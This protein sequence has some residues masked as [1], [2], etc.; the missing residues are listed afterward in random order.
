[1]KD[2]KRG[3]MKK[4]LMFL[5]LCSVVSCSTMSPKTDSPASAP[6]A[7]QAETKKS[8]K[9]KGSI[10]LEEA[11]N[12]DLAGVQRALNISR[13][14]NDLG[15]IEKTF[16]TCEVGSG[17]SKVKNCRTKTFGLIHFRIQCRD[18]DG[19]T[20]EVVTAANL[21]AMSNQDLTWSMK[22]AKGDATTDAQ[23]YAQ[24]RYA[25]DGSQ[26]SQRLRVGT[27]TDFLYLKANEIKQVIVPNYWCR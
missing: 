23:G 13:D 21:A 11:E 3:F 15:V 10:V 20:S 8:S 27:K 14:R 9:E 26:K 18:T 25:A 2:H 22:N 16:N 4:I 5:C 24:I 7:P 12:V 1:M 17:Y 19:T 6:Q